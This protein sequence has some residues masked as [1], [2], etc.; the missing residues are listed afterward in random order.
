M[1]VAELQQQLEVVNSRSTARSTTTQE[2]KP[3]QAS[4]S[5]AD[6]ERKLNNLKI[7]HGAEVSK[8]KGRIEELEREVRR[9]AFEQE[10][11]EEG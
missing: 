7:V 6:A 10:G 4:I 11:G 5:S 9:V 2:S 1:K 8:L 3:Y